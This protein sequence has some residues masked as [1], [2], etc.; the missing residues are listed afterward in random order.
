MVIYNKDIDKNTQIIVWCL[1]NKK[2]WY[3]SR[4]KRNTMDPRFENVRLFTQKAGTVKALH[5]YRK[6]FN[7]DS[8]HILPLG[9]SQLE[10]L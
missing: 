5:Y 4:K 3:L 6:L 10:E 9:V 8:L 7:D 1:R 2:L